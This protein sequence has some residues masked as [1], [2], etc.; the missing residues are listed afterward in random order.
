MGF[1]S[2]TIAFLRRLPAILGLAIGLPV[3]SL[4]AAELRFSPQE[5]REIETAVREIGRYAGQDRV[6]RQEAAIQD[7]L[8]SHAEN[9]DA[10][11]WVYHI[12]W[13]E[14]ARVAPAGDE[15]AIHRRD[16]F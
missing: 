3:F 2:R 7:L 8:D 11:F 1:Q 5:Q 15:A 4:Q 6:A 14:V 13:G 16:H 10:Q 9:A 12:Y